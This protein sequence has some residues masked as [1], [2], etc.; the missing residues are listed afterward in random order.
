MLR[1]ICSICEGDFDLF[2]QVLDDLSPCFFLF[3]LIN[4]A[5]WLPIH[6]EDLVDLPKKHPD[7]YAELKKGNFEINIQDTSNRKL[8]DWNGGL[9]DIYNDVDTIALC[10]L[11]APDSV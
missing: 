4:Y 6:I 9:A 5:R 3:E 11:A 10:M 8:Q 2:V 7:V 1:F